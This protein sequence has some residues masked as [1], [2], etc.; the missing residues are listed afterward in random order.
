LPFF[1]DWGGAAGSS[2]EPVIAVALRL[3]GLDD[4]EGADLVGLDDD[5]RAGLDVVA[6]RSSSLSS[7]PSKRRCVADGFLELDFFGDPT[8]AAGAELF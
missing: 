8:A 2:S 4:G 1:L 3:V 7:S 6:M 5:V